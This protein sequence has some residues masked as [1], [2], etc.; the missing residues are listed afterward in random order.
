MPS[1]VIF[2]T[3]YRYVCDEHWTLNNNDV[4][5]LPAPTIHLH[6]ATL[7]AFFAFLCIFALCVCLCV[8]DGRLYSVRSYQWTTKQYQFHFSHFA[9]GAYAWCELSKMSAKWLCAPI[10]GR[11]A[12]TP[13]SEQF[14]IHRRLFEPL[15][16]T[17]RNHKKNIEEREKNYLTVYWI[18]DGTKTK[19]YT[20]MMMAHCTMCTCVR[21]PRITT[22]FRYA[23]PLAF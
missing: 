16:Q 20:K 15:Q 21:S 9:C 17:E 23:S 8:C 7:A 10:S 11:H 3:L 13:P 14:R 6:F 12:L 22:H 2:T 1:S 5:S 19:Q 18:D 4:L